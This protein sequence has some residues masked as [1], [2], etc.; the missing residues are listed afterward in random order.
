MATQ[1]PTL[2][3]L[4]VQFHHYGTGTIFATAELED[5]THINFVFDPAI[6]RW[7]ASVLLGRVTNMPRAREFGHRDGERFVIEGTD[8]EEL[9]RQF[10][11]LL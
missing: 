3:D 10:L 6:E 7:K 2:A 1:Y 5:G 4:G 9:F 8:P 11:E